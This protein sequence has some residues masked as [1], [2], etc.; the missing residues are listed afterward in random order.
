M[1]FFNAGKTHNRP[2]RGVFRR[3]PR[4]FL[5]L[6]CANDNLGVNKVLAPSIICIARIKNLSHFKNQRYVISYF[7]IMH[8]STVLYKANIY[9]QGDTD[10]THSDCNYSWQVYCKYLSLALINARIQY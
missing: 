5:P 10:M 3:G 7:F 9:T 2:F 8:D 4:Q 6:D 1:F